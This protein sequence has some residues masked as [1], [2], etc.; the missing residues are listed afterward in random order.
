[1]VNAL[2]P[3]LNTMLLT[4]VLAEV[5]T[6]VVFEEANVAVSDE[7]LGTVAGDQLLAVFQSPEAGLVFEVALPAKALCAAENRSSVAE[8]TNRD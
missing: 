8:A 1:M 3:V 7:P 2:A 6:A 5:E 4:S